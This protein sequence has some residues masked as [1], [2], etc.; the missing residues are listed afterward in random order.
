MEICHSNEQAAST[1]FCIRYAT[2]MIIGTD[3]NIDRDLFTIEK[4]SPVQKDVVEMI[5]FAGYR[6]GHSTVQVGHHLYILG[7]I[8]A[9]GNILN[10]VSVQFVVFHSCVLINS[11]LIVQQVQRVN[12][13]NLSVDDVQPMKRPRAHFP[14]VYLGSSIY[15]IGANFDTSSTGD[16]ILAV[17]RYINYVFA[18]W[19]IDNQTI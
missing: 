14:S 10:K 6:S 15:A 7:G 8:D 9:E 17:E 3:A 11:C 5:N 16:V 4:L 1:R 12:I 2:A 13:R 18:L 19:T